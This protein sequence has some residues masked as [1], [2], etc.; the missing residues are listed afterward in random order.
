MIDF[1]RTI[2]LSI[3]DQKTP[4][5]KAL[6]TAEE[7][8]ELAQAVLSCYGAPCCSYK[9]K[10]KDEILAEAADV[11]Q[12]ALSVVAKSFEEEGFPKERF[13]L[14]YTFKLDK[15]EEKQKNDTPKNKS[16]AT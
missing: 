12:C 15:W 6:K 10:S 13:E 11:I 16:S 7:T 8:G 5:Q 4:E 3:S 2:A 14:M 1:D 9:E